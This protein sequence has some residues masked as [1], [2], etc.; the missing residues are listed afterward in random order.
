VILGDGAGAVASTI[1]VV[2]F[3]QVRPG[4]SMVVRF[5]IL[6]T[7]CHQGSLNATEV[8]CIHGSLEEVCSH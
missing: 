7:I 1:R 4:E 3:S 5:L 2:Y 8:K 6:D